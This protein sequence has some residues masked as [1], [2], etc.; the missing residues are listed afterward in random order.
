MQSYY[1]ASVR[2]SFG[3]RV[4]LD[5]VLKSFKLGGC[6]EAKDEPG[7]RCDISWKSPDSGQTIDTQ[8]RFVK[9]GDRWTCRMGT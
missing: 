8:C 9:A 5:D 2:G 1:N 7:Y 4:S 6:K 3:S